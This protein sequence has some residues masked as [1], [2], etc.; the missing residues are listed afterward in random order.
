MQQRNAAAPF[1][2]RFPQGLP[3]TW[4]T[5][6]WYYMPKSRRAYSVRLISPGDRRLLAEFALELSRLAPERE[7][8]AV[9]DITALLF[10][11]VLAAG[12]HAA[13]GFAALES[14]SAGDRIIGT[15]A[16]SPEH[17]GAEFG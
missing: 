6:R 14:T 13:L 12:A 4:I 3:G 17:D 15:A 2:A 9:R 5:R 1:V 10:D 7:M 16:Y 11:R 8:S